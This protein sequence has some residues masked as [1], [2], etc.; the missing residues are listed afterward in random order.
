MNITNDNIRKSIAHKIKDARIAH[1]Y[2]QENVAE[3]IGTS[4]DLI[5]NIENAR[6]IGS[7][8]T[9]LKLCN[10]L[11]ITPNDLFY[12]FIELNE[13]SY[14]VYLKNQ[15]DKMS[16]NNKNLLKDIVSYIDEKYT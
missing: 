12:D 11:E 5:R 14:D 7:I 16:K 1:K 15:F 6:N 8:S 9:I 2:T 3:N 4:I 13:N 10:F